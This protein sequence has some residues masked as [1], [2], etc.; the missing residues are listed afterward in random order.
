MELTLIEPIFES[1]DSSNDFSGPTTDHGGQG[2]DPVNLEIELESPIL[3]VL[4][5]ILRY[6]F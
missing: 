1:A 2:K 4:E 6:A 5:W 3:S